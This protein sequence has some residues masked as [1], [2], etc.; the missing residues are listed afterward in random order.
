M[1]DDAN[2]LIFVENPKTATYAVKCG[3]LGDDHASAPGVRVETINHDVPSVIN[4][5]YPL[6]WRTY[7]KFVV[8]RNT[9][10]RAN[11]FFHYYRTVAD[12]VSYQ[13]LSFEDWISAGCPPP[14]EAHLRAPM[15]GEGRFDDVLCQLRYC[16][17]VDQVVVLQ[18]FDP[19]RRQL[20]LQAGLNR[21]CSTVG[22]ASPPIP[23]D[24]NNFGRTSKPIV[25]NR[26][27]VERL[28]DKYADEI[29]R[30]GFRAPNTNG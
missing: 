8:V 14:S 18:S 15:H 20:E 4:S 25:W 5:K 21:V 10:D 23:T 16:E 28:L 13:G 24:K 29:Q 3:L 11:S 9:W 2:R 12:S 19:A 6:E 17:G 26:R 22:M 7:T 27:S 30:F 1:I